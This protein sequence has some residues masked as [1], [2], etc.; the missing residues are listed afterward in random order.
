MTA[1][2]GPAIFR[3]LLPARDLPQSRRFYEAILGAPGRL[4]AEGRVYFDCGEVILGVLDYSRV[5]K[6]RWP[7]VS[8][9]IYFAVSDLETVF[10]RAKKLRCLTPGLLHG[11]NDSPLGEVRVRPW[12]ERSFYAQDP[13]GN[14]ICFVDRATVFTGS[15]AQ[16]AALARAR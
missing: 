6:A 3:L 14:P 7:R 16:V 15:R 11:D 8:E 10:R 1:R 9:A 13:A 2:R 4:V 5:P 12:G